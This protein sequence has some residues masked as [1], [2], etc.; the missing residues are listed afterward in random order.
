MAIDVGAVRIGVAVAPAG[1][2]LAVPVETVSQGRGA[3]PRVLTLVAEYG[4]DRVYV[5]DPVTLAG[6]VGLAALAARRFAAELANQSTGVDVRMVDER[7]T[8]AQS[9]RQL[10][11]AGRDTRKSRTVIDQAAAVAIL[12]NAVDL[13]RAT[14]RLAG[15]RVEQDDR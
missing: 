15:A 1:A 9:A 5:G 14:G 10:Q 11:A 6:E 2:D 3:V 7:L 13:E 4:V 8:T 12:Q